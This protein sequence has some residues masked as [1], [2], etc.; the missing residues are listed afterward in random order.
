MNQETFLRE[1]AAGLSKLSEQERAQVLDYYRELIFDGVENGKSEE[2]VIQDF[3][4]PRDIAAQI[5]A[6]YHTPASAQQ[7]ASG[8]VPPVPSQP[9]GGM[10]TYAACN[11]VGAVMISAQNISVQ[12]QPVPDGPVR[13]LFSPCESD[14]ITVTEEN[15]VFTFTHM[16]QHLLF[17]WQDLFRGPRSILLQ[18]PVSFHGDISVT[19]CNSKIT[20]ENLREIGSANFTNNNA[21][22]SVTNTECRTLQLKSSN[23]S[24]KLFGVTGEACTAITS[25]S[26]ISVENSRF[27]AQ[28]Q[29]H[30]SNSSIQVEQGSSDN[31]S[32]K[33]ANGSISAMLAGDAREYAIHSHTSNGQ[34]NL[35]TDWSYPGQTKH[36]SAVT[37]NARINVKFTAPAV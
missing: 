35:P 15:G 2:A 22:I 30:T 34:N 17:H 32:M 19:T 26:R 3:G 12:V 20:A 25:N 1:L 14:R 37:S 18:L 31:I 28:L 11:P 7:P 9:V 27:P 21:H 29:L 6:E 16:M 24:L 36:L 13:V 10:Q 23:G 33:T 4:S 5:S 8:T